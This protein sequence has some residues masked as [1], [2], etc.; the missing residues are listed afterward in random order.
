[1]PAPS[2]ASS[3]RTSIAHAIKVALLVVT[4]LGL[5]AC[6]PTIGGDTSAPIP[7]PTPSRI[8]AAHKSGPAAIA[9]AL[10]PDTGSA[11]GHSGDYSQCPLTPELRR[12]LTARPIQYVD[13]LCRC[14]TAYRSPIA[15]VHP[16]SS[17]GRNS[18]ARGRL[19]LDG[20]QQ[21]LDL[22]VTHPLGVWVASDV[23]CAGR[24][25]S[26][27]VFSDAPTPCFASSG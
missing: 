21:S 27:S 25:T 1:M 15:E 26:I 6:S 23:L 20:G 14:T 17:C 13:Q 3:H 16:D 4:L 5:A 9:A 24:G 19:T 22:I 12:R 11:C 18:G 10:F 2:S 7:T 8:P